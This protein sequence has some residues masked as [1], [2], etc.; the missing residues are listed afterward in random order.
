MANYYWWKGTSNNFTDVVGLN[1]S[2]G[3]TA[4]TDVGLTA[5]W[6]MCPQTIGAG[7]TGA[8]LLPAVDDTVYIKPTYPV[9][10]SVSGSQ[11]FADSATILSPCLDSSNTGI[12][13]EQCFIG[14]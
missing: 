14:S 13:C 3:W 4:A 8:T 1:A 2:E 10:G 7:V 11:N 9:V 5:N 6:V 12:T